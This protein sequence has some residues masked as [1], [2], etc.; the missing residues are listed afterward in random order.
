MRRKLGF[1]ELP[2]EVILSIAEKLDVSSAV[3]LSWTN[4]KLQ[5]IIMRSKG[6]WL[7][8]LRQMLFD[9]LIPESAF[10]LTTMS[11]PALITLASRSQR[12]AKQLKKAKKSPSA[13][14]QLI[15]RLA[16]PEDDLFGDV[17]EGRRIINSMSDVHILPGGRWIIA[18]GEI[19]CCWDILH[20]S[21]GGDVQPAAFCSLEG[22]R[23]HGMS[24]LRIDSY[25]YSTVNKAFHILVVQDHNRFGSTADAEDLR[26]HAAILRLNCAEG[27]SPSVSIVAERDIPI[28]NVPDHNV[29][30]SGDS[31][32]VKQESSAWWDPVGPYPW[33]VPSPFASVW[34]WRQDTLRTYLYIPSPLHKNMRSPGS[35]LSPSGDLYHIVSFFVE[36]GIRIA[37]VPASSATQEISAESPI[38]LSNPPTIEV[39]CQPSPRDSSSKFYI[40]SEEHPF[41]TSNGQTILLLKAMGFGSNELTVIYLS[42]SPNGIPT[43]LHHHT[44]VC[45]DCFE[46]SPKMI[47]GW[48]FGHIFSTNLYPPLAD[49]INPRTYGPGS[50]N[51]PQNPYIGDSNPPYVPLERIP[52]VTFC[53]M[54]KRSSDGRTALEYSGLDAAPATGEGSVCVRSGIWLTRTD[55]CY[56]SPDIGYIEVA[57]LKYM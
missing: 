3:R 56:R 54:R 1:I 28:S 23:D 37:F 53:L 42:I 7:A 21:S 43:L 18:V 57:V 5:S 9:E 17:E 46:G 29:V 39:T 24:W 45:E 16:P 41:L 8:L 6:L 55:L 13:S 32:L 12:Y 49:S 33:P 15:F 50:E 35:W 4:H 22:I 14:E 11:V 51:I 52:V 38:P 44:W 36:H 40:W 10:P 26:V 47:H 48:R 2:I 34:N 25:E 31:V 27:D 19:I 20:A 30:L